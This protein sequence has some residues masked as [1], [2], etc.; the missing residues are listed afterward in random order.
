M[1]LYSLALSTTSCIFMTKLTNVSALWRRKFSRSPRLQYSVITSTG[2]GNAMTQM[3]VWTWKHFFSGVYN[4]FN[5]LCH[6]MYWLTSIGAG[7]QQIDNVLVVTQVA[8]DLQLRHQ[9]LPLVRVRICYGRTT[10]KPLEAIRISDCHLSL[11]ICTLPRTTST[12]SC[13]DVCVWKV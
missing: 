7:S 5:S 13:P 3:I 8:Q 11:L 1:F 4:T 12:D 6:Q 10:N 9:G 2:P